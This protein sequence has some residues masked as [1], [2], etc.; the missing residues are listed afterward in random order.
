[1]LI[2][3]GGELVSKEKDTI[4]EKSAVVAMMT[5]MEKART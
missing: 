1:M 4:K 2:E 3:V 5:M